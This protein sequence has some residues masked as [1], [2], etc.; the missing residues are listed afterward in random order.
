MNLLEGQGGTAS[1]SHGSQAMGEF[2]GKG[3]MLLP[4]SLL[5]PKYVTSPLTRLLGAP[6][7]LS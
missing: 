3:M 4:L 5:L 2:A 7:M 6:F 1:I